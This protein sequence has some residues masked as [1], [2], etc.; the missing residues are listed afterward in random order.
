MAAGLRQRGK[1]TTPGASRV[2]PRPTSSSYVSLQP[3]ERK[4]E[5]FPLLSLSLSLGCRAAA[6][7][8]AVDD[9][10]KRRIH[11]QRA[12]SVVVSRLAGERDV[13]RSGV[14]AR[15][16]QEAWRDGR[17]VDVVVATIAFGLGIDK[18]DCRFVAHFTLSKAV[19]SYCQ[20]AG[21]AG[22]DGR[23][24]RCCIFYAAADLWRIVSLTASERARFPARALLRKRADST[25]ERAISR[26]R[27][28]PS[29]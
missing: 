21:R 27:G 3:H 5:T 28:G 19:E 26:T 22:R 20:E 1:N 10:E 12:A 6:Y 29:Q 14:H 8:A 15:P 24:A 17:G 18:P 7:H 9:S 2:R 4:K 13:A 16:S 11:V 23:A 25:R